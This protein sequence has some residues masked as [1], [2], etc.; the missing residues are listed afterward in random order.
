[1]TDPDCHHSP[2]RPCP[3]WAE[4]RR[5]R[6]PRAAPVRRARHAER[7]R[8]PHLAPVMLLFANER[9]VI[10]T[11][12]ATRKAR[13]VAARPHAS[14]LVQTPEAAW[15]RGTG[16]GHH[17]PPAPRRWVTVTAF[18]RNTSQPEANRHA[19]I[20][21]PRWRRHHPRRAPALAQLG[22]PAFMEDL[23]TGGVDPTEA[24]KWYPRRRD[25]A[26]GRPLTT[27]NIATCRVICHRLFVA[28]EA[29]AIAS[30]LLSRPH[31]VQPGAP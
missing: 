10:E 8:K 30:R 1:M 22:P 3:P 29:D 28:V 23:A 27:P 25:R 16:P 18:A 31:P 13:S 14:V 12:A 24:D 21:S 15:V 26:R 9:I 17:H 11:G 5:P 6:D 4:R 20:N 19:A 2:G 7:R